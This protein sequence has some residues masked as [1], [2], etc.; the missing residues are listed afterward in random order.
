MMMGEKYTKVSLLALILLNLLALLLII[1]LGIG[2]LFGGQ[3]SHH[4]KNHGRSN[5]NG[6]SR[7]LVV[8]AGKGSCPA[9]DLTEEL[10]H[11]SDLR[12][13]R[14]QTRLDVGN[15]SKE[16][17]LFDGD[18]TTIE[19]VGVVQ[20]LNSA[21]NKHSG[22]GINLQAIGTANIGL[23][24][25]GVQDGKVEGVA[26]DIVLGVGLGIGLVVGVGCLD[27][28]L[29]SSS[30]VGTA[31]VKETEGNPALSLE[32]RADVGAVEGEDEGLLNL[33]DPGLHSV[34]VSQRSFV[35]ELTVI[36]QDGQRG[37]RNTEALGDCGV[38]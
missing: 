26:Q 3:T 35:C 17:V 6:N 23:P 2:V 10:L 12:L 8:E 36:L 19:T 33:L 9:L 34:T 37:G 28:F 25:L 4:S 18:T 29:A 15:V 21:D 16:G 20:F 22:E 5:G 1:F 13:G 11:D 27:Q 32:E 14:Q 38:I 30:S 31:G 7:V 24:L